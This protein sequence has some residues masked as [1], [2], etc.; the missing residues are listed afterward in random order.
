M[1]NDADNFREMLS[2]YIDGELSEA[3]ARRLELAMQK[4]ASLAG[5]LARL[6]KVV[7]MLRHLEREKAGEDFA[8]RVM[9]RAERANLVGASAQVRHHAARPSLMLKWGAIAAAAVVCVGAAIIMYRAAQN[10]PAGSAR[11]GAQPGQLAL[12]DHKKDLHNAPSAAPAAAPGPLAKPADTEDRGASGSAEAPICATKAGK[13]ENGGV[14][15]LAKGKVAL[16]SSDKSEAGEQ[17]KVAAE[18]LYTENLEEARKNVE[19]VLVCN[20]VGA[21]TGTINSTQSQFYNRDFSVN[22]APGNVGQATSN[23]SQSAGGNVG[24]FA[25]DVGRTAGNIG[26]S[27]GDVGQA[28]GSAGQIAGGKSNGEIDAS[29]SQNNAVAYNGNFKAVQNDGKQVQYRVLANRSQVPQIR[30]QI[31]Q[32]R[33]TNNFIA[34]TADG[35]LQI[36][37]GQSDAFKSGQQGAGAGQRTGKDQEARR[38]WVNSSGSQP[39]QADKS[40]PEGAHAQVEDNRVPAAPAGNAAD[41]KQ[42]L[43]QQRPRPAGDA[44]QGELVM[45]Q[46]SL[47]KRVC[48]SATSPAASPA[49]AATAAPTTRPA[50]GPASG[51]AKTADALSPT[52]QPAPAKEIAAQE[53]MKLQDLPAQSQQGQAQPSEP[54]E[55]LLI[56]INVVPPDNHANAAVQKVG[57]MP[58]LSPATNPAKPAGQPR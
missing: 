34:N 28:T 57:E 29:K 10:A 21:D 46:P 35:N 4:D 41:D 15:L 11:M 49:T 7:F 20:G 30:G 53:K 24:K 52:S 51:L 13:D 55:E 3:D 9:A 58:A 39:C 26:K 14:A 32:L 33:G 22:Q 25:S 12:S 47:K 42:L 5:E 31:S 27:A 38:E 43:A 1:T 54:L 18:V 50:G 6:R 23:I 16:D 19:Q 2:A 48:D 40:G 45:K 36:V 8:S 37:N 17:T 44:P 56:T